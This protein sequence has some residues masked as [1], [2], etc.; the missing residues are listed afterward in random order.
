M[1]GHAKGNGKAFTNPTELVKSH[2]QARTAIETQIQEGQSLLDIPVSTKVDL[3]KLKEKYSIWSDYNR[4]LLKTLFTTTEMAD[5]YSAFYGGSFSM[6]A[7]INERAKDTKKDISKEIMRLKSILRRIDLF[8]GP[9]SPHEIEAKSTEYADGVFIVH[10]HDEASKEAVARFLEKLNLVTIILHEQPNEG[11]TIIEKFEKNASV[12]FAVVLLTL[13]DIGGINKDEPSLSPRARQNVVFELG[14]F[15]AK[16]GRGRVCAIC[17]EGLEIPSDIHGVLYIP[18]D[19][20][21]AWKFKLAREMKAAGLEL[22]LNQV[23]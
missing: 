18:Y 22:D 14:Y 2:T 8:P 19:A 20:E 9:K 15:F 10:G 17:A 1:A 23:L 21:G 13:D 4:D 16:L 11:Q 6:N 3:E 5:E 12:G 7:S